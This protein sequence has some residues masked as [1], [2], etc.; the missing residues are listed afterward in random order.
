MISVELTRFF[1]AVEGG[2]ELEASKYKCSIKSKEKRGKRLLGFLL[3]RVPSSRH[4][5]GCDLGVCEKC[6][7]SS[8]ISG[9]PNQ[10]LHFNNIPGDSHS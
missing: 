6:R 5:P 3:L 10:N 7:I 9:L 2:L 1:K 4:Q 8:P